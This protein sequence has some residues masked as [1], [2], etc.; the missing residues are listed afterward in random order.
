MRE[1]DMINILAITGTRGGANA[2]QAQELWNYLNQEEYRPATIMHGGAQGVDS[3]A[4]QMA[5]QLNC[6]RV[7]LPASGESSQSDQELL[8]YN[9]QI[10]P[11]AIVMHPLPPLERDSL[12]AYNCDVLAG[13]VRIMNTEQRSGTWATIRR[14]WKY[15]RPTAI[16]YPEPLPEGVYPPHVQDP[17]W[18][19]THCSYCALPLQDGDLTFYNGQRYWHVDCGA[20]VHDPLYQLPHPMGRQYETTFKRAGFA[21]PR[22]G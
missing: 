1:A 22:I 4:D 7:V 15:G 5:M 21:R 11:H 13:V 12:I 14:A 9:R 20:E 19:C 8:Y 16:F 17:L 10:F 18:M 6:N 3:L 2:Y